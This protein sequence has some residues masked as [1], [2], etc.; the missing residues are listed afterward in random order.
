MDGSHVSEAAARTGW[1]PR[2]LRYLERVGLVVPARSPAGY[3]RYGLRELNQL[4]ALAD[5]RTR[6]RVELSD[7]AFAARLRREPELRRAVDGWL[8]GADD[9]AW[10]EWEQRKHE[11][12]LAA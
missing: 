12:L 10:V 2:M 3:R 7:V 9:L 1:S 5:L 6:F 8:A 4:R 11:R